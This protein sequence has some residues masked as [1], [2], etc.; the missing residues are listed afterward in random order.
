MY[1]EHWR[2]R[3][4]ADECA[5][6]EQCMQRE[7]YEEEERAR[8]AALPPPQ[9]KSEEAASTAYRAAFGWAGPPPVYIDF[10]C[11]DDDVKG[12]ADV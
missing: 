1:L 7:R 10:T 2:Q 6:A 3:R 11:S 8:V 12:K 4:L 5:D 9:Q